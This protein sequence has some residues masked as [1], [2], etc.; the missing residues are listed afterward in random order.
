MVT[1]SVARCDG[2]EHI[3][4]WS[5]KEVVALRG[6]SFEI[7]AGSS[8][9]LLGPSGSGKSTLMALLAGLLR[10]TAGRVLIGD[11]DVGAVSER[12]L[13]RLRRERVGVVLQ[14]PSRNLLAYG[15]AEQNIAFAQS[16]R[17]S[18]RRPDLP[19]PLKLLSGL[20]LH[21]LAGERV[22]RMSGGEQQRLAV[23][24][25]GCWT[26]GV[27][28]DRRADEPTGRRPSRSRS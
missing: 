17:G 21:E 14:N 3:H 5:E 11:V 12:E 22:A 13:L 4:R 27:G 16:A 1:P 7:A 15:T 19:R 24:V 23:A 26:S 9:A 18:E 10:P 2:V 8:A 28:A 25:G 20:R 6:T